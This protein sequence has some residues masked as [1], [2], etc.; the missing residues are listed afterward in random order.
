VAMALRKR[1]PRLTTHTRNPKEIFSLIKDGLQN[2]VKDTLPGA[3][4]TTTVESITTTNK[5]ISEPPA[6]N[7]STRNISNISDP[8]SSHL[9]I[10]PNR[11]LFNSN[12]NNNNNNNNVNQI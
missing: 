1:L 2:E 11:K 12:N 10:F 3:T 8:V 4:S 9:G 5:L 7:S 6:I